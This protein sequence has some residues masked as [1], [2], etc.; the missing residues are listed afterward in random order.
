MAFRAGDT[1]VAS[2]E[3][4]TTVAFSDLGHLQTESLI[5]DLD[6]VAVVERMDGHTGAVHPGSIDAAAVLQDV[7]A[8]LMPELG[9]DP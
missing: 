7:D 2:R 9:M 8:I 1:T 4:G 3:R 6:F 5:A